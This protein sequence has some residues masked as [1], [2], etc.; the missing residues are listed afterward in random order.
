MPRRKLCA[1]WI[2]AILIVCIG[3][4]AG[5]AGGSLSIGPVTFG[6]SPPPTGILLY[7]DSGV[8]ILRSGRD[9]VRYEP[10]MEVMSGDTI[11]TA[12]GQ[13]VIDYDDGSAVILNRATRVRLGSIT[14]FFGEVF[15]R[16]KSIASRGG[17]AVV[18]DELSASVEGTE[19][20][21]RR[22]LAQ[23]GAL[24][25]RVQVYVRQGRVL[26][27][28]GTRARWSPLAVTANQ[29]FEVDGYRAEPAPRAVDARALSRWADEAERRLRRPRVPEIRPEFTVPIGPPP[30][31][32]RRYP[33]PSPERRYPSA[34]PG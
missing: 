12:D 31:R 7:A 23:T 18:T 3:L 4:V 27:A 25:G 29:A 32:E 26:C 11:E 17:G 5:C 28:P 6:G 15:A 20:G 10:G 16:I 13:A 24:L 2:G 1:N 14:L 30:T 33:P 22:D 8:T 9:V 34:S 19:F 21:V